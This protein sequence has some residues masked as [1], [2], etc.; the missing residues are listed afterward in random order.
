MFGKHFE[1]MYEGSMVGAGAMVFAVMGYIIAKW[2][3][4]KEVG[5]QV[6]LNPALLG[7][8][9]GETPEGVQKAI[10]YLCSPDPKTS[11]PGEEGRR[12][13][14]IGQ[15]DYR[16]VNAA[17]YHAMRNEEQRREQNR[18]AQERFRDKEKILSTLTPQ[19]RDE[20]E[21]AFKEG[22]KRR[23]KNGEPFKADLQAIAKKIGA[24]QAVIDGLREATA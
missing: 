7:P 2:K 24:S 10:D 14:R 23:K 6:R 19:Q 20:F 12:L 1:S 18:A 15:Y 21:K 11:T 3:P 4:D 13:V 9:L 22:Y 8:I 5:G 16:V 17:K